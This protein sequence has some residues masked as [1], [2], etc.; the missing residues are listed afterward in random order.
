VLPPTLTLSAA[1]ASTSTQV[2]LIASIAVGAVILFP[3]LAIL[4]R[5]TLTGRLDPTVA[6]DYPSV[7]GHE[8]RRPRRPAVAALVLVLT[9]FVLLTVAEPAAAHAVGVVA[10]I[11]AGIAAFSAVGPDEIAQQPASAPS[12]RSEPEAAP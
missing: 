11:A 5:L 4:F 2:A 8:T 1:A 6:H 9:G 3:S 10:L 7:V 12:G